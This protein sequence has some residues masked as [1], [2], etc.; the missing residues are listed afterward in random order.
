MKKNFMIVASILLTLLVIIAIIYAVYFQNVGKYWPKTVLFKPAGFITLDCAMQG[1]ESLIH[2]EFFETAVFFLDANSNGL[3][4]W[5]IRDSSFI[6]RY[7]GEFYVNENLFA[8][9][10]ATATKS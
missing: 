3:G 10:I 5:S 8:E 7:S 1:N 6:V 9:M 4:T 2:Y